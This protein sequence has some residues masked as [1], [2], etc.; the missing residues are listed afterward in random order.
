MGQHTIARRWKRSPPPRHG[1]LGGMYTYLLR[2]EVMNG[3]TPDRKQPTPTPITATCHPHT[4]NLV[5]PEGTPVG[6]FSPRSFV[7]SL[8]VG[9]AKREDINLHHPALKGGAHN[10]LN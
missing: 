6:G 8:G 9:P 7:Q 4:E 10:S 1:T 5:G 3:Q 2:P